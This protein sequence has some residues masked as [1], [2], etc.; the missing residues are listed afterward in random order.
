[1]VQITLQVLTL[2]SVSCAGNLCLNRLNLILNRGLVLLRVGIID[3]VDDFPL[4][5]LSIQWHGSI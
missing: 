5:G 2:I 3:F 4:T 1:M